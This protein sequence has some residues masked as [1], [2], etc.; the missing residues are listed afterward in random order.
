MWWGNRIGRGC[1]A[2]PDLESIVQTHELVNSAPLVL[3]T[4]QIDERCSIARYIF[5]VSR[6]LIGNRL[7][8]DLRFPR[9]RVLGVVPWFRLRTRYNSFM[10]RHAPALAR[11]SRSKI[12]KNCSRPPPSSKTVSHTA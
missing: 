9:T 5:S 2:P 12:L 8:D 11:H 10:V 6:A 1:E 3:G 4:T 7:A